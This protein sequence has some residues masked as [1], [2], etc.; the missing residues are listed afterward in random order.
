MWYFHGSELHN[1]AKH[2][3]KQRG[4]NHSLVVRDVQEADLGNYTCVAVNRIG[5]GEVRV[6]VSGKEIRQIQH[7][8]LLLPKKCLCL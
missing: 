5:E 3:M 7:H 4:D 2:D 1:D 8:A 6:A